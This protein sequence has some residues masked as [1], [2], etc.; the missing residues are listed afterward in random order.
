MPTHISH[1]VLYFGIFPFFVSKLY[2][3]PNTVSLKPK[4]TVRS[5][6]FPQLII[7]QAVFLLR[8]IS[9]FS[10]PSKPLRP[11]HKWGQLQSKLW[12][13]WL[14]RSRW[15]IAMATLSS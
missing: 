7:V 13:R 11:G 15:W 2:P 6:F 14:N 9:T 3:Q 4:P 1:L 12:W 8:T 5:S 10:H